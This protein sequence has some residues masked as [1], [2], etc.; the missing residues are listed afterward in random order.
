MSAP[1]ITIAADPLGGVCAEG[2]RDVLSAGLLRHAGFEQIEDRYGLRWRLH[3]T[4]P[5]RHRA[6]MSTHA[7]QM[8]RA[9]RYEVALDSA[10]YVD[11]SAD[12][13]HLLGPH[14]TATAARTSLAANATAAAV[15]T[16]PARASRTR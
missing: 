5:E 4:T 15:S 7:A 12:A 11:D 10:L 13:S 3:S 1:H 2:A 8:L 16:P 6:A 9:A 14:A